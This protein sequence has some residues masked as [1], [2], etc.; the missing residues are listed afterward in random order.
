[1]LFGQLRGIF[2][3]GNFA[4]SEIAK[5]LSWSSALLQSASALPSAQRSGVALTFWVPPLL[6]FLP[7]STFTSGA[8]FSPAPVFPLKPTDEARQAFAGAVHRVS[9]PLDG[10]SSTCGV[11]RSAPTLRDFI[12]CREHSW[13]LPFRAFSSPPALAASRQPRLSQGSLAGL[14]AQV[15]QAIA[16]SLSTSAADRSREPGSP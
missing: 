6:R 12:S 7:P 4:N 14:G 1:M 10:F 8:P 9:R 11:T 2:R 5:V 13:E 3:G 16:S 15:R